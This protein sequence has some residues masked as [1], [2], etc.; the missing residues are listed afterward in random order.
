MIMVTRTVTFLDSRKFVSFKTNA[1]F[2]SSLRPI[3][4]S[5]LEELRSLKVLGFT[6]FDDRELTFTQNFIWDNREKMESYLK[7]AEDNH[8]YTAFYAEWIDYVTRIGG[9]VTLTESEV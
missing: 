7:W 2:P 6:E 5:L 1:E 9:V 4:D 8:N 3:F